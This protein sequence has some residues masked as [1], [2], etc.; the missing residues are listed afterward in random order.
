MSITLKLN[1]KINAAKVY[2]L[3]LVDREF[4]NKKFNKFHDQSRMKYTS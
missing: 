3:K 4:L 2:L 1:V